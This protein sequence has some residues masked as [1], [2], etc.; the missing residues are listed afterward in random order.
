[1]VPFL[2]VAPCCVWQPGSLL[3]AVSTQKGFCPQPETQKHTALAWAE[4]SPIFNF[5]TTEPASCPA[6]P[7]KGLQNSYRRKNSSGAWRSLESQIQEFTPTLAA[8]SIVNASSLFPPAWL[9]TSP[10][11][12]GFAPQQLC[13]LTALSLHWTLRHPCYNC[14]A[15]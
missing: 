7:T 12:L 14:S 15:F 4:F 11:V 3:P 5:V 6:S 13:R 2:P 1:M 10:G 9:K 8:C